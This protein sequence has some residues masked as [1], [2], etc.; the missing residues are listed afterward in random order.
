MKYLYSVMIPLAGDRGEYELVVCPTVK[1]AC[2]V[3]RIILR[4][5]PGRYARISIIVR[6]L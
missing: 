1:A 6:P 4:A 2:E 3:I 5:D